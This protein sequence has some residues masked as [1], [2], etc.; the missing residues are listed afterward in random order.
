[1]NKKWLAIAGS[2]FV[3]GFVIFMFILKSNSLKKTIKEV[4]EYKEYEMVSDMQILENDEL[5]SYQVTSTYAS[6]NNFDYYKIELYDKSLNQSQIIVKNGEGVYVTKWTSPEK[7][8][9]VDTYLADECI[10]EI[11]N[12]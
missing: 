1:M 5:K 6:I 8:L 2:V 7:T 4:E 12:Y 9:I 3:V 10:V 11:K